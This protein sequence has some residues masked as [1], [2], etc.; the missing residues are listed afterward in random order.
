VLEARQA[1]RAAAKTSGTRLLP[2]S[3]SPTL[4]TI[5]PE[6]RLGDWDDAVREQLLKSKPVALEFFGQEYPLLDG[7]TVNKLMEPSYSERGLP[8][9]LLGASL[10]LV[11]HKIQTVIAG[12]NNQ[13][14]VTNTSAYSAL[15]DTVTDY[16]D[17][18]YGSEKERGKSGIG[19]VIGEIDKKISDRMA[20]IST[21]VFRDQTCQAVCTTGQCHPA[22]QK[23]WAFK[24]G[25]HTYDFYDKLRSKHCKTKRRQQ[26]TKAQQHLEVHRRAVLAQQ[27]Q[28]YYKGTTASVH[29]TVQQW[30]TMRSNFVKLASS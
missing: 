25:H 9:F 24:D 21:A 28:Q 8:L 7:E 2:G 6:E 27:E 12:N 20:R 10:V 30:I 11:F 1:P 5:D 22:C 3:D 14:D 17:Y 29:A 23:A 13:G 4:P 16:I 15:M 19:G 18:A 26:K